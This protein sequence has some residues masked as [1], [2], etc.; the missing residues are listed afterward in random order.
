MA[1][2]NKLKK[3]LAKKYNVKNLGKVK[4]IIDQQIIKDMAVYIII[5]NQSAFIR[6]LV[7]KKGLIE[8]NTNVIP[9]KTGSIIEITKLYDYKKT[10]L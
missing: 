1:I 4:T 6:N 5:I 7:I 8:Y 3:L 2:L 10:K 9:I